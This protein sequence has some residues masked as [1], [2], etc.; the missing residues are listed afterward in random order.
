MY[1]RDNNLKGVLL[2]QTI[3]EFANAGIM[4]GISSVNFSE[5]PYEEYNGFYSASSTYASFAYLKYGAMRIFSQM[6]QDSQIKLGK[7]IWVSGHSGPETA[8]DS[9]TH[10]GIFSPGVSGLF[11]KGHIINL[12][13]WEYNEVPVLLGAALKTDAPII[14]LHLTRPPIE[15][16]DREKLGMASHFDA[17]KGAYI[18]KDYNNS[19]AKEGVVIIRGSKA[20]ETLVSLLPK[21]KEEGPNVKIVA[22]ISSE[23]FAMQSEEYRN[24]VISKEEWFDTMI[25]TN[26]S[27]D[28]MQDWIKHPLAKEYSLSSDWDNKWRTGGSID[29]VM[30]EAHLSA[31]WQWKAIS[32]FAN[33]RE[34]RRGKLE[35]MVFSTNNDLEIEKS[36][37]ILK[38]KINN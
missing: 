6:S 35:K 29:Q 38:K 21:L 12:H 22:A 32:K 10:F 7:T 28:L 8:E 4:T 15:I 13:P 18:I 11:P 26:S 30:D 24:S 23:L 14:C 19:R 37:Y 2:P 1:N 33:E 25:I 16:P 20:T 3:T 36:S 27:I 5:N 34:M 9:R 17:A 31:T